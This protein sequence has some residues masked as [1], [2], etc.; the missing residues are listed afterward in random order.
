MSR[1]FGR[2]IC[3]AL[4]A[5]WAWAAPQERTA[6]PS[7]PV[8]RIGGVVVDSLSGAQLAGTQVSIVAT[9]P[10]NAVRA[11]TTGADGRFLFENV[12]RGKYNLIARRRGYITQSFNEHELFSTAIAVG[13]GPN[14]P[15]GKSTG[16]NPE[17]LVFRLRPSASISGRITDGM[18]EAVRDAQVALYADQMRNGERAIRMAAQAMTDFE[19]SYR[20]SHLAPGRYFVAVSAHPWYAQPPLRRAQEEDAGNPSGEENSLDVAYPVTFY[21]AATEPSGASPITL[22]PGDRAIANLTMQAVPALHVRIP[23]GSFES[24][25]QVAATVSQT[26]FDGSTLRMLPSRPVA[27]GM[28]EIDGLTPGHYKLNL[29]SYGGKNSTSMYSQIDV[30]GNAEL[31]ALDGAAPASVSGT[32][33]STTGVQLPGQMVIQFHNNASGERFMAQVS[34]GKFSLR[35][36]ILAGSYEVGLFNAPG[37]FIKNLSARGAKVVGQKLQIDGSNPVEVT[38]LMTKGIGR[39]DGTALKENKPFAGAMVV[40]VPEDPANNAALFRRDQSDSDGTFTLPSVLPGK[41]TVVA[42]ENGWELEWSNPEVLKRYLANGES[43]QVAPNKKYD[44]SV[45][46]Q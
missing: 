15:G 37:W 43:V 21:P 8:F 24:S 33:K 27:P 26:G 32:V 29:R 14:A 7:Q 34:G 13:P 22:Q 41:Y 19:G 10:P 6:S 12:A 39:V 11:T 38:L 36:V 42:I 40:L 44:V 16:L 5:T 35:E 46:V 4:L 18:N 9:L 20:F 28:I 17:E 31:N 3:F 30:S 2:L 23:T 25:P 45:K 1:S